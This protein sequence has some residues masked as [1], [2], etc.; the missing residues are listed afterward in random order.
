M[1]EKEECL[2]EELEVG[3]RLLD[4]VNKKLKNVLQNTDLITLFVAQDMIETA[5]RKTKK[6]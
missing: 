4:E 5:H 6:C 1:N 2:R 3:K